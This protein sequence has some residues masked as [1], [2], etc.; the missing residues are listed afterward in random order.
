MKTSLS[1]QR[2]SGFFDLGLSL[3][4]LAVFGATTVAMTAENEQ[5]PPNKIV[6]YSERV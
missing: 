3:V 2:Q 1:Y 6:L 5:E 4:L